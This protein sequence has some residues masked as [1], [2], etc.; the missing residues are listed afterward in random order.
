MI[1][2]WRLSHLSL[3]LVA[4]LFVLVLAVT[5]IILAFEPISHAASGEQTNKLDEVQLSKILS[6]VTEQY[7]ECIELKVD[8]KGFVSLLAIDEDGE[9][10]DGRIDIS[11]GKV[12]AKEAPQNDFIEFCRKFHR[13]LLM[14]SAGRFI[15]GITSFLLFLIA[16]SG[17]GLLIKQQLGFKFFFSAIRTKAKWSNSHSILGRLFLIPIL[18]IAATGTVMTLEHFEWLEEGKPSITSFN[19]ADEPSDEFIEIE[20]FPGLDN[21]TLADVKS[22]A[23]PMLP[24]DGEYFRV[25][26]HDRDLS[27][28]QFNGKVVKVETN[29]KT[30]QL[31]Q[32]STDIHTGGRGIT[33]PLVL[34]MSAFCLIYLIY[35]GCR[36]FLKRTSKLRRKASKGIARVAI[37]YGSETGSTKRFVENFANSLEGAKVPVYIAPLN[38]F[39]VQ[40]E[41]EHVVIMTSTYGDGEAPSNANKFLELWSSWDGLKTVS[42]LGFGSTSYP[43]FCAYAADLHL[44]LG[45]GSPNYRLL[46]LNTVNDQ[47]QK[48]FQQWQE[49]WQ[50]HAQIEFGIEALEEV[51]KD[52]SDFVLKKNSFSKSNVENDSLFIMEF[53]TKENVPFQSGDL[54][55]I[56]PPGDLRERFYSIAKIDSNR[57]L[58]YLRAHEFGVCSNYLS[59]LNEGS[60]IKA[61]VQRNPHFHLPKDVREIIYISNGTGLGPYFGF[62]KEL[63]SNQN[64]TLYWGAR[65]ENYHFGIESYF[66]P[67]SIL[68]RYFAYSREEGK[69]KEYVQDVLQ[70]DMAEVRNALSQGAVLMICGGTTMCNGVL[71]TLEK[72]LEGSELNLESLKSKG[73]IRIDCY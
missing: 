51:R 6:Q 61:R 57:L 26:L 1:R 55:A 31:I 64:M 68:K 18:L 8:D 2:I 45:K 25:Q 28:N 56:T 29:S 48:E 70:R 12:I 72:G 36:I 17:L 50:D 60:K 5:G 27:I 65:Y 49:A 23:F 3:A 69:Q 53:E 59:T 54:L 14:G 24:E 32:L 71:H 63:E 46:E 21:I 19:S 41:H 10:V 16:L 42:I 35:S 30:T 39:K 34:M 11:S 7:L 20:N 43:K 62:Q 73:Q 47:N 13:S 66:S 15:A 22:V 38:K 44:E 67:S 40:A 33:W 37:Y 9:L 4:G 52:S 58:I